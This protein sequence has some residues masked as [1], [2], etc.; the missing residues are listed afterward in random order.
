MYWKHN[1]KCG[2][3]RVKS[4][5]VS[6]FVCT[7]ALRFAIV[8]WAR[9]KI[10]G[11]TMDSYPWRQVSVPWIGAVFPVRVVYVVSPGRSI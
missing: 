4:S 3:A 10:T 7:Y 8:F 11:S 6:H 1:P 5:V 9:F 2:L